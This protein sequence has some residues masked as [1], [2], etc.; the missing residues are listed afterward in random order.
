[1]AT[2]AQQAVVELQARLITP[3]AFEPFG[4]LIGPTHDGKEFDQEDAQLVLDKGTPRYFL[5]S[6]IGIDT[7]LA[8]NACMQTSSCGILARQAAAAATAQPIL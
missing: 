1:M 3:E 7:N 2:Q 6:L 5:S 4:Q 8:S